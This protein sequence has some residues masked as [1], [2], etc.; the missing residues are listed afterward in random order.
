VEIFD[1]L[2][3]HSHPCAAVD[4]KFCPAK[5]TRVAVGTAKF[6]LN[7][8]NVSP[9]WGEKPDFWPVSKNNTGSLPLR[10]IVPV[11]TV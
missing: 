2:G 4:V 11:K 3:P 5:R 6:H 9:L 1:I 7:R 8:C 10:G